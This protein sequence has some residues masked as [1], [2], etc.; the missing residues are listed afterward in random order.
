MNS[1]AC[2]AQLRLRGS[3]RD[4]LVRLIAHAIATPSLAGAVNATAP[5]PVRN[6]AFT[7]EAV[8]RLIAPRARLYLPRHCGWR[9][10]ISP[11]NSCWVER[12]SS[13]K[14]P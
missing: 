12:V 3:V 11:K 6:A 8:V 1:A 7:R 5:E 14:R 4:D 13:P 10:V 9:P 2:G